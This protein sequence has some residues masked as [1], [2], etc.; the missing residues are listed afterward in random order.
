MKIIFIYLTLISSAADP[1][2]AFSDIG[3][4][5]ASKLSGSA[6]L[7]ISIMSLNY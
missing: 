2:S 1:D 4:G 7:L 5:F 6:K 3:S